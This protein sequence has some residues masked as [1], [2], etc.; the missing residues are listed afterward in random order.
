MNTKTLFTGILILITGIIQAQSE[1]D[2]IRL[3]NNTFGG[4]ARFMSMGGAFGALGADPSVSATNPGGLALM[5]RS[6]FSLTPS[7]YLHSSNTNFNGSKI[8]DNAANF[9][10]QNASYTGVNSRENISGWLS[11]TW[12]IGYSRT[13][14]FNQSRTF[15][16]ENNSSSLLDGYLYGIQQQG[17]T[18]DELEND[19]AYD[20]DYYLAW[21]TFLID[22]FQVNQ[23][24]YD[25]YVNLDSYNATQKKVVESS[26]NSGQY[27]LSYAGNYNNRF[28]LGGGI[29]L[30][31]YEYNQESIFNESYPSPD[32]LNQLTFNEKLTSSGSGV[33][34]KIGMVYRVNDMARVG[35]AIHSP[36][37]YT[38]NERFQ[39]SMSSDFRNGATYEQAS[40]EYDNTYSFRTP[41]NIQL[42]GAYIL[43]KRGL[44]SGEYHFTDYRSS[45]FSGKEGVD[46]S[47]SN[48]LVKNSLSAGHL[49][50]LGGEYR[51]GPLSIRGGF[52]W[53]SSPY[54]GNFDDL[55]TAQH[56]Y[57]LGLGYRTDKFYVDLA[58][59]HQRYDQQDWLYDARFISPSSVSLTNTTV[60]LS[61]GIRGF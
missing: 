56:T 30:H 43:G 24:T 45:N 41:W 12:N 27:T 58:A 40:L 22:T 19:L 3:S 21:Q 32:T 15:Q 49:A 28:F 50:A 8:S 14:D 33:D 39:H 60:M 25:Y 46:L 54:Q 51:I 1:L 42:S 34:M 36:T 17:L 13:G 31:T 6:E 38:V 52:R 61:V 20:L 48:V 10:F 2:A 4:T 47:E 57:S 55:L 18:V 53:Q 59:A 26:G 16:G 11:T 44:V 35:L 9:A 29:A 5:K 37:W 23:N 7:L